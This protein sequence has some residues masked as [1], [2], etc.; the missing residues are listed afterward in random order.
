MKCLVFQ[1]GSFWL[2]H[3]V[4]YDLMAQ[5]KSRDD[6]LNALDEVVIS[7][8]IFHEGRGGTPF[9]GKNAAPD[10]CWN[11]D[12]EWLEYREPTIYQAGKADI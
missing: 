12:G 1:D 2:A 3:L 4:E 5:G 10:H 7:H 11:R 9:D 8:K 6:A